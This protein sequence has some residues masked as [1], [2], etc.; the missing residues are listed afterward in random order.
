M[1][2]YGYCTVGGVA[3]GMSIMSSGLRREDSRGSQSNETDW[4]ETLPEATLLTATRLSLVLE[5]AI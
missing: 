2:R 5:M 3:N 4:M 1:L